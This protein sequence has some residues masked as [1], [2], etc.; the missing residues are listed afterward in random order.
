MGK[1]AEDE[2]IQGHDMLLSNQRDI[3]RI[4]TDGL[5]V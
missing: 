4:I 2:R 5:V 1:V 3:V